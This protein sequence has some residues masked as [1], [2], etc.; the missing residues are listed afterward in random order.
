MDRN[1][2]TPFHFDL[3]FHEM[4]HQSVISIACTENASLENDSCVQKILPFILPVTKARSITEWSR[5]LKV[6]SCPWYLAPAS[7]SLSSALLPCLQISL[8]ER[9][10][11]KDR[12]EG[13]ESRKSGVSTAL[14][15]AMSSNLK[16]IKG[17]VNS[18]LQVL[19]EFC[20][21]NM[22]EDFVCF[23]FLNGIVNDL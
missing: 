14:K 17:R 19:T 16:L 9:K 13:R 7:S 15:A 3:K 22:N 21:Q 5:L 1:D 8:S 4:F 12:G 18:C 11:K 23:N 6:I 20:T 10:G 2:F